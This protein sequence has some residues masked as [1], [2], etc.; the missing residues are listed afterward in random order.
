MPQGYQNQSRLTVRRL[1]TTVPGPRWARAEVPPPLTSGGAALY[2]MS[3]EFE[4]A[5]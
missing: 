2:E 4:Y 5:V 3:G 1:L